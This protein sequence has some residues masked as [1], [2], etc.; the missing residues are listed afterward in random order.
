LPVVSCHARPR[1]TQP[2]VEARFS[3]FESA[4]LEFDVAAHQLE[5]PLEAARLHAVRRHLGQ[6]DDDG[7][8][9]VLHGGIQPGVGRLDRA[10]VAAP[11]IEFPGSVEAGRPHVEDVREG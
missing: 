1:G 2:L 7:V 10:T 3:D 4:F 8:V 9:V 5:A 11:E 6:Q